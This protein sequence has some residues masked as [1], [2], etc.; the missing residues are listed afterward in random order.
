MKYVMSDTFS[1]A[2]M[3]ICTLYL[4]LQTVYTCIYLLCNEAFRISIH[5]VSFLWNALNKLVNSENAMKKEK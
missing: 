3:Q 5:T 2:V 4:K 1:I